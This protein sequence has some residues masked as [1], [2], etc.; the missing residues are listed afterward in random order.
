[1]FSSMASAARD[2]WLWPFTQDSIWNTPIGSNA[3]YY[4]QGH[5][6]QAGFVGADIEIH[7]KTSASDPV[8]PIYTINTWNDRCAGT[9]PAD[10]TITSMNI[11][12][13]FII[14]DA[15]PQ[16]TPNNVAAF[17]LPNGNLFQLGPLCRDAHGGPV[18]GYQYPEEG[19]VSLQSDGRPGVHFGS[20]LSGFGGTV[21]AG[22]LTSSTPIRHALKL[23][24]FAQKYLYFSNS[25]DPTQNYRWPAYSADGYAGDCVNSSYNCYKGTDPKFVM[26]V[27]LAIPPNVTAESLGITTEPGKKVFKALQD[28]GGY[29]ADDASWDGHY[30]SISEEEL[31]AFEQTYGYSFD[32]RSGSWYD[33]MNKIVKALASV[34]NN[35]P[36]SVGGGGDRR[37]PLADPVFG[38]MDSVV[39]TAPSGLQLVSM[40]NNS[41]VLSWTPSTDNVKVARYEIYNGTTKIGESFTNNY[42]NVTGL[43]PNTS[44]TLRVRAKDS[45]TNASTFSSTVTFTTAPGFS[46]TFDTASTAWSLTNA[47]IAGNKLTVDPNWLVS[48]SAIYTGSSF[49]AP[50]RFKTDLSTQ[51]SDYGNQA[52]IYF[53]YTDASNY[54]SIWFTGGDTNTIKLN[55]TVNGTTTTLATAYNYN[56]SGANAEVR[57]EA[58][59]SGNAISLIATKGGSATTIFNKIADSTFSSGKI[60]YAASYQNFSIDNVNVTNDIGDI[61]APTAPGSLTAATLAGTNKI[62]LAWTAATDNTGVRGY[63]IYND[64][65]AIGYTS[66]LSYTIT[67][68]LPSRTYNLTVKAVDLAGNVSSASNSTLI[69]TKADAYTEGFSSNATYDWTFLKAKVNNYMLQ[70]TNFNGDARATYYNQIFGKSYTYNVA[71]QS[72]GLSNS[73]KTR[74]LFNY[75][76]ANNTYYVEFGGGASNTVSLVRVL[77]GTATTLATYAGNYNIGAWDWPVISINYNN[78]NINVTANRTG[79]VTNLFTNI[80]DS[81]IVSGQIGVGSLYNNVYADTISVK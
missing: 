9:N 80:S 47:T 64:K 51:G 49:T 25:G 36:T 77:N 70:L 15:R 2:P 17:L 27:L 67:N 37:A 71:L 4:G 44:Y 73:A 58:G 48:A 30:F 60:G 54:Y 63:Y 32:S 40:T 65:A 5:F 46:E 21:R 19:P 57:L 35:S 59:S 56:L 81:N 45:S 34:D 55:K 53:N 66:S 13:D 8:R 18:Y 10:G 76:D 61:A 38:T 79:T 31:G 33:D 52:Q 62:N 78:G 7:S 24:L 29:Y 41:A 6:G 42:A 69:T 43:K 28:Y 20:R 16:Y 50:Y 22:D 3:V 39:P 23:E 74:V 12:D 75:V 68:P 26:G 72:D 14:P 1:M 11:P